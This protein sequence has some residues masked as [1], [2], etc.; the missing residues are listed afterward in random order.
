M[1]QEHRERILR[2]LEDALCNVDI[3]AKVIDEHAQNVENQGGDNSI[4]LCAYDAL[5]RCAHAYIFA[6][7]DME[8]RMQMDVYERADD[9]IME[10]SV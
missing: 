7:I 8:L 9:K 10:A 1:K 5:R 6:E 4:V 2:S 3:I